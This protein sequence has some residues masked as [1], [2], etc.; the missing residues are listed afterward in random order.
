MNVKFDYNV[1]IEELNLPPLEN[2]EIA[3]QLVGKLKVGNFLKKYWGRL[4]HKVTDEEISINHAVRSKLSSRNQGRKPVDVDYS[5]VTSE[6]N[7]FWFRPS[8]C[9]ANVI[10]PAYLLNDRKSSSNDRYQIMF[11]SYHASIVDTKDGI[12]YDPTIDCLDQL[13]ANYTPEEKKI[14][15]LGLLLTEEGITVRNQQLVFGTV[16]LEEYL[17]MNRCNQT[18]RPLRDF[19]NEAIGREAIVE[20]AKASDLVRVKSL[21]EK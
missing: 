8:E 18:A 17:N 10:V 4:K 5:A 15:T 2:Y 16:S 20:R 7:V 3:I 6:D 1:N 21:G 9:F 19:F 12:I 13:G 11:N 14:A